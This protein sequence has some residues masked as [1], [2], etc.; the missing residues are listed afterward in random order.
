MPGMLDAILP[1]SCE[2][3]GWR[4][5]D[6]EASSTLQ[7]TSSS[8]Q[9]RIDWERRKETLR[10]LPSMQASRFYAPALVLLLLAFISIIQMK[11][12]RLPAFSPSYTVVKTAP[13]AGC[14]VR[15]SRHHL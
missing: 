2:I 10:Q 1:K 3:D 14:Q 11:I 12:Q 4:Q 6:E 5:E 8:Q 7:C 9:Q 13:C 15:A